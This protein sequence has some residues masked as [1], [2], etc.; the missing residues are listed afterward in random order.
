MVRTCVVQTV[1]M[2]RMRM[3]MECPVDDILKRIN[4]VE[5]ITN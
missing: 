2:Q 4:A 1:S 3:F 5:L